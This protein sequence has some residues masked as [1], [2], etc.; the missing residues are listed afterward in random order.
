MNEQLIVYDAVFNA[1][2]KGFHDSVWKEEMARPERFELP[3]L[4]FE[5]RCS[6][7]LSYGRVPLLYLNPCRKR[8]RSQFPVGGKQMRAATRLRIPVSVQ[9]VLRIRKLP[10]VLLLVLGFFV[11]FL[12]DFGGTLFERGAGEELRGEVCIVLA[13]FQVG[14]RHLTAILRA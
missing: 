2:S 13:I 3:T 11:A 4:C 1:A 12:G 14:L 8:Q 7:Q 10:A 6:I 9:I 5:G